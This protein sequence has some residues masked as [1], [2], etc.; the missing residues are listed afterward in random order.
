MD[1]V[2]EKGIALLEFLKAAATLRRK[3]ISAY[4]TDTKIIWFADL[5]K[6]RAECRSA[7]LTDRPS[8]FGDLWLEVRKKRRPSLPPLPEAIA[9]WVRPEDLMQADKEPE[10]CSEITVPVEKQVLD[11]DAFPNS[12]STAIEE[13]RYL[14]D[15]P[16]IEDVWGE[17][18]AN[19]WKPWAWEMHR[20]QEVQRVYEDL[21]FMRRRLEE[22]EER[23]ELLLA[24]GLLQ[25]KDPTGASVK[26]HLLTAPAEISLDAARG[27]LTVTPAV[28]FDRFRVELDMLELQHQPRLEETAIDDQLDELGVEAWDITQVAPILREIANRIH[29]D[30]Q[31]DETAFQPVKGS[32]ETPWVSYAPALV[33][34]E[35]RP[36][37]YNDLISKFLEAA[38]GAGWE[39]VP[40]W[41]RLLLEGASDGQGSGLDSNDPKASRRLERFLFPLPSN[42]EQRQIVHRLQVE[43]CVLVKGP[44]GTGKSHTIANLICHLLALGERVLVTAHAPKALTVLRGLLPDDIRDLCVTT[45]GSSREDHRLLEESVRGILRRKNDW[46]GSAWAQQ[47]IDQ[48][49][50]RLQQIEDEIAGI[51]RRLRECRE[52]ETRPHILAGGYQGTA[53]EIARRVNEEREQF[54]WFPEGGCGENPFP[55]QAD[56]VIFLAEMHGQLTREKLEELRFQVGDLQLPDPERFQKLVAGLR[57]AEESVGK[58]ER[59]A[60]SEKLEILS[61][62]PLEVLDALHTVLAAIEELVVRVSRVLGELTET[63]VADLLVSNVEPWTRLA[64]E[65]HGIVNVAESLLI[66]LGTTRV[67]VPT[68]VHR[69]CLRTDVQRRRTHF[70]QGGRR[71][72]WAFSPRIVKETNYI[73][74]RC[75]VDGQQPTE[76]HQL[77]KVDNFLQLEEAIRSFERI[78]PS[79]LA[80][81][82]DPRQAAMRA[83]DLTTELEYTLRV[84]ESPEVASITYLPPSERVRLI[85][86]EER[87]AWLRA[88]KAESARRDLQTARASLQEVLGLIHRCESTGVAHPCLARLAQAVQACDVEAWRVA[89]EERERLQS[90]K[91]R[92][93]RYNELVEKLE[94][95]CQG[96]RTLLRATEGNP[97]WKSKLLKLERA[98]AW[99]SAQAWLR[100]ISATSGYKE[101]VQEF[102]RLQKKAEKFT[103]EL[104]SLRAWHAFFERLD[105]ATVQSLN[106]WTKAVARIGKGTGKY[107]YRHRRTARKYLTNCVPK[108]PAWV[109]PLHKLWDTVDAQ[110]GIFDTVIVDEASQAGI[111]SLALFLLAKR[112]IIVG[113]DKQNSPEAVGVLE[114][115]IARLAREH[116]GQFRFREEFRPDTSLFDHAERAFG[117]LIPLREHFRCVPEIIRFS[118]DLCYSD[119][120][121]IPLRQAPPNRLPPLKSKFV[122]EGACEGEGQ[123]IRNRAEAEALVEV[124]G[125]LLEDPAYEGKTMGVIALQGHAQAELI[126]N[127]LAQ[128]LDP[129]TMEERR[130]RCGEPATFQGDQRDVMFLSLVI[131]PNVHYR[132]L[133][134]LPDQRRFNVAMSRARDQVWLFH[135]VQQHDLGP[136]D[137]RRKLLSFFENPGHGESDRWSEDLDTLERQARGPRRR[138]NQPEPYESWFEVDVALEL[139]RRK[140]T[141]RPQVEIAGKRI[142][143]VIDGMDARLA[144]ECDGDAWHDAEHYEYDMARQRQLERAGWTFVRVRESDFYADREGT[145]KT[146][147]D[148]CE[149]LGIYSLDHVNER[150]EGSSVPATAGQVSADAWYE[151][152]HLSTV[153]EDD[154]TAEADVSPPDCRLFFGDP[155]GSRFPD[156][157]EASPASVRTALRQII[158]AEGPLIRSSVYRLYVEGCPGLKRVGRVVRQTL[159]QTLDAMLRAG[160]IVQEDELDDGSPEGQVLRLSWQEGEGGKEVLHFPELSIDPIRHEVLLHGK[161]IHLTRKELD[162]LYHLAA[163][164]GRVFDCDELLESVWGYGRYVGDARTVDTHIKRLRQK[165]E[166]RGEN[167]WEIVT[168]WGRGY[169]FE[170]KS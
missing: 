107:A 132:A 163:H 138:G 167:P 97:E 147:T 124:I 14:S 72:F 93:A 81:I 141:V 57:V 166:S 122:P 43:P 4:G 17:Y 12:Q 139:L 99:S 154:E 131:A 157:R 82:S 105:D 96:L 128:R 120:P 62:V 48:R 25:W 164:P 136:D 11:P 159:N 22:S 50:E 27:V 155:E 49:E 146:I 58:A 19:K 5:P 45:L 95:S 153:E 89:W 21:D 18:L 59:A 70:E 20:W 100:H 115:D 15:H 129:K 35:R 145:I 88:L 102:H 38:D 39:D 92:F 116:L 90:E 143:L 137:L 168:I 148:A 126:E 51:E 9:E 8:E 160:E 94:T 113:D 135:S 23:Y 31:V 98:W 170:T 108:I 46:E 101:W 52:A 104:V 106:A 140:Y 158:E 123:R 161:A 54:G 78:W 56:E 150:A 16:E 13:V 149:E 28:S 114:D 103:E 134:R 60:E 68:D 121:L 118:N 85:S 125:S 156:P 111:E 110:P 66:R 61:G 133:N 30:A 142:D 67:E 83:K 40:P 69:D 109:M 75:R 73:E 74:K 32:E 55:L 165:L 29:A 44:P 41:R 76:P 3:R 151:T 144:V 2:L 162:L 24:V 71:S 1:S 152:G 84:F 79:D 77:A 33:L 130:L 80:E 119:A 10:L 127:L 65:A 26:R 91:Q 7:F 47:A 37:A 34:R 87:A 86:R 169:K 53:A 112:I 36:T 63:I 6:E 64:S 42:D 117:T